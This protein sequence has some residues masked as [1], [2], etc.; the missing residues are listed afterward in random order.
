[1]GEQFERLDFLS[2]PAL[3]RQNLSER[4]VA[5]LKHLILHQ[6]LQ[7]GDRLPP[8]RQLAAA[9]NV[10]RTVLR[11]ALSRLIGE[12]IVRRVT[13]RKLE[14]AEFDRGKVSA[15][16]AGLREEENSLQSLI[17]LR[18]F[19]EIGA[20]EVIVRRLT[21]AQLAEIERWVLHGEEKLK[22]GEPLALVDAHFH[23]ALLRATENPAIEAFLPLIEETL[24]QSLVASP[25]QFGGSGGVEDHRVVGEHRQI[26]EALRRRDANAARLLMLAHLSPY[27]HRDWRE[28]RQGSWRIGTP[29]SGKSAD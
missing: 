29:T 1:M 5:I 18:V 26:F 22:T 20:L 17:E 4:V 9:I 10:S 8:E 28:T 14:I 12:G 11:E 16:L 15:E 7:T 27:L 21:A 13:P 23:A 19:V 25:H 6:G 2:L 24:R 3:Q